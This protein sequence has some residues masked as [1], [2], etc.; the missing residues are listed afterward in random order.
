L[1]SKFPTVEEG[2]EYIEVIDVGPQQIPPA[3]TT[4]LQFMP[5]SSLSNTQSTTSSTKSLRTIRRRRLSDFHFEP[6]HKRRKLGKNVIV[7]TY[8]YCIFVT[9][10]TTIINDKICSV[11]VKEV[12][13]NRQGSMNAD[14]S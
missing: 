6:L 7:I 12:L 9:I 13:L 8:K 10:I 3:H 5:Q 2:E 4:S 1:K 14:F 11:V